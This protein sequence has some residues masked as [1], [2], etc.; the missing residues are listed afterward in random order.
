MMAPESQKDDLRQREGEPQQEDEEQPRKKKTLEEQPAPAETRVV[1]ERGRGRPAVQGTQS[2][3]ERSRSRPPLPTP[4][5][6]EVALEPIEIAEADLAADFVNFLPHV[7]PP[8][9]GEGKD[10]FHVSEAWAATAM[11]PAT[12]YACAIAA[13]VTPKDLHDRGTLTAVVS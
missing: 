3:R 6:E 8:Q 11:P 7:T 2:A 12:R 5:R 13:D 10:N 4:T 1:P 9:Q